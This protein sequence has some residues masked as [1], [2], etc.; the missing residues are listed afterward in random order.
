MKEEIKDLKMGSSVVLKRGKY[1][2]WSGNLAILPIHRRF[3]T[4]SSQ[5]NL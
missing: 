5:S 2:N 3:A 1:S 4:S